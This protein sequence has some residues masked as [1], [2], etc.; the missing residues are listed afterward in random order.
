MEARLSRLFAARLPFYSLDPEGILV[1]FRVRTIGRTPEGAPR[2]WLAK[3][4]YDELDEVRVFN[5]FQEANMF[6]EGVGPDIR[7]AI[8][9]TADLYRYARG[10]IPRPS[11][12]GRF[13]SIGTTILLR[14]R[15]LFYIVSFENKDA[16]DLV[17]AFKEFKKRESEKT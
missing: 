3:I 2:K 13:G 8:R 16:S 12:Y 14:G 15:N 4:G 10:E 6:M 11:F 7:L 5:S 17:H 9:Q 1:D